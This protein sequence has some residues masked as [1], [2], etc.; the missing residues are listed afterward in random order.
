MPG[1]VEPGRWYDIQVEL[2]GA[3]VK[4]YLDD[5]LLQEAECKPTRGLDAAAGRDN[6]TDETILAVTNPG[7]EPL[8]TQIKPAG[9]KRVSSPVKAI[10]LASGSLEDENSF[11]TSNKVAPREQ[12]LAASGPEFEHQFP[13]RR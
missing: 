1:K 6:Q 10:V 8:T 9:A 2:K 11:A 12:S 5:K 7:G 13:P 3:T 4:C